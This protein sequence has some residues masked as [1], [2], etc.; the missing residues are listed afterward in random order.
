MKTDVHTVFRVNKWEETPFSQPDGSTK[1]TRASCTQ[2]YT[3]DIEGE[4]VL[5]YLMAYRAGGNAT[6]VG[7]ERVEGRVMGKTGSFV[8]RHEGAY[9]NGVA[10]M[11][12]T[13]VEGA[14]TG[15]LEHFRGEGEFESAHASEYSIT[16]NCDFEK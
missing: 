9:E 15:E 8:L 11:T 2:T 6:F 10:R 12:M 3:G 14:G 7:I 4:S 1:L 16:L 13:V 5:E